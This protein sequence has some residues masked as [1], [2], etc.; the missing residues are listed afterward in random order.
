MST[1]YVT[2]SSRSWNPKIFKI[3]TAC[4]DKSPSHF[5]PTRLRRADAFAQK[6]SIVH[7]HLQQQNRIKLDR[8]RRWIDESR[9]SIKY[10]NILLKTHQTKKTRAVPSKSI[11]NLRQNRHCKVK[12]LKKKFVLY[13]NLLYSSMYIPMNMQSN[14]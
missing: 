11:R 9:S 14:S 1:Q 12:S 10:C 8:G 5:E 7:F 4:P 2:P 13:I 6:R 3:P